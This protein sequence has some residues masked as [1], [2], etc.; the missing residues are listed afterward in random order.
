MSIQTTD[1]AGVPEWD[2]SDRL[3]KALRAAN[4]TQQDMADEL[5]VSRV[6]VGNWINGHSDPK[7]P[8]LIAWAFRCGVPFDWLAYGTVTDG[9]DDG[10]EGLRDQGIASR[11]CSVHELYPGAASVLAAT[12]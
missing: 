4:I 8:Y 2:L 10:P 12:G 11:R 9:P 7:R 5:E 6:T 1:R 3:R